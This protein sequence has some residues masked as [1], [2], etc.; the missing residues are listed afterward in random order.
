[1]SPLSTGKAFQFFDSRGGLFTQKYFNN[2]IIIKI[3][4]IIYINIK[5]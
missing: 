2:F 1:L 5:K 4:K 3:Y